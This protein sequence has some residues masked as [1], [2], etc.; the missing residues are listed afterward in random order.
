MPDQKLL[1]YIQ[2]EL[3]KDFNKTT[4]IAAL[5]KIGWQQA[6][7]DEAFASIPTQ[8]GITQQQPI[9]PTSNK[10]R[11]IKSSKLILLLLVILIFIIMTPVFFVFGI[12]SSHPNAPSVNA[13]TPSPTP[14]QNNPTSNSITPTTTPV[15]TKNI[16]PIDPADIMYP[17]L[18]PDDQ[19]KKDLDV[20]Q[21]ALGKY[22]SYNKS[23]PK[24]FPTALEELVPI[25][26]TQLL[27]DPK[28]EKSY[29]YTYN[30]LPWPKNDYELCANF[31]KHFSTSCINS[32]SGISEIK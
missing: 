14:S 10:T 15:S 19:R 20:I 1:S 11:S 29:E 9:P 27:K 24:P 5:L 21:M 28:T 26:L 6:Q 32:H 3:R 4:I 23:T 31:D 25:Y 12:I 2:E 8:A 30:G 18:N 16:T 13:I 17:V 7:I 22:A